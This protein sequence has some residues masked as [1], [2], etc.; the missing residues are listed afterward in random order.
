[1]HLEREERPPINH[2]RP[3]EVFNADTMDVLNAA[4]KFIEDFADENE[5]DRETTKRLLLW[6]NMRLGKFR[7]L[8]I[9]DGLAVEILVKDEFSLHDSLLAEL[10][11]DL[12]KAK[13]IKLEAMLKAQQHAT[14]SMHSRPRESRPTKQ[15]SGIPKSLARTL[16]KQGSLELCLKYLSQTGYNGNG[17]PGKCFS[18]YRAH[19]LPNSLSP[20]AKTHIETHLGGLAPEFVDP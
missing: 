4:V 8:V 14:T 9:S 3:F 20:E 17:V 16:P 1:M 7:G 13:L 5:P 19:F 10:L 11:Y 6:I 2:N 12:L 15:N 18:K